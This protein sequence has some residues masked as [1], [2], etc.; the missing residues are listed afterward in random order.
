MP[1]SFVFAGLIA[2]GV[3]VGLCALAVAVRLLRRR[4]EACH[5]PETKGGP[6]G[7][8]P[9]REFPFNGQADSEND[10]FESPKEFF[11]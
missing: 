3:F 7:E 1:W 6:P 10:S 8:E 2:V 11:I 5:S 4:R 9:P